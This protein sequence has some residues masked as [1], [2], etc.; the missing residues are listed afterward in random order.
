MLEEAEGIQA[1][2]CMVITDYQVEQQLLLGA[3]GGKGASKPR[4][5]AQAPLQC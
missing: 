1:L 5:V 2:V 4:A 3:D